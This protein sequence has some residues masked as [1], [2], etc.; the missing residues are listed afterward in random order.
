M[1]IKIKDLSPYSI[2]LK[3][4]KL[5]ITNSTPKV[6]KR[7]R[8]LSFNSKSRNKR[9]ISDVISISED[10][11]ENNEE[12]DEDDDEDVLKKLNN[13]EIVTSF[14]NQYN[15]YITSSSNSEI[16]EK[17]NFK[18]EILVG[19]VTES[20]LVIYPL[21]EQKPG[22][23]QNSSFTKK[24]APLSSSNN[25]S[26]LSASND[27]AKL[28]GMS[29]PTSPANLIRPISPPAMQ[30]KEPVASPRVIT[31]H[32]LTKTTTQAKQLSADCPSVESLTNS[33]TII[34]NNTNDA[35]SCD[36]EVINYLNIKPTS[37][38]AAHSSFNTISENRFQE[39]EKFKSLISCLDPTTNDI[40]NRVLLLNKNNDNSNSPNEIV[41]EKPTSTNKLSFSDPLLSSSSTSKVPV[42]N[43]S[44]ET[45]NSTSLSPTPSSRASIRMKNLQQQQQQINLNKNEKLKPNTKVYTKDFNKNRKSVCSKESIKK[46]VRN[47]YLFFFFWTDNLILNINSSN[48]IIGVKAIF[49]KIQNY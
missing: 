49:S 47:I 20:N 1:K 2:F 38:N 45:K 13:S 15:N 26:S 18:T 35:N 14:E 36:N 23:Q 29:R 42:N 41:E 8:I 43:L 21:N 3:E 4:K 22:K 46:K 16:E 17:T 27:L 44:L 32:L 25:L 30:V 10:D 7:R 5:I 48:A 24:Q 9:G 37:S 39:F 19:T 6:T 11:K 31:R 28:Q 12:D 34:N 40:S 33:S